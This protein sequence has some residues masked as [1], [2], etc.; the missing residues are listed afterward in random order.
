LT[1]PFTSNFATGDVVPI[2]TFVPLSYTIEFPIVPV[3]VN[4]LK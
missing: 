4:L 1:L 3:D 2:P